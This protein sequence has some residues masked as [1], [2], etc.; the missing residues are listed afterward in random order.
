MNES[1]RQ[2]DKARRQEDQAKK[3]R[4]NDETLPPKKPDA[5]KVV[6]DALDLREVDRLS[7]VAL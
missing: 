2:N 6:T 3:R 1:E 4:E 7:L 5:S